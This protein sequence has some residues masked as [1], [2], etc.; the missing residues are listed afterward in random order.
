[1]KEQTKNNWRLGFAICL[2]I[3]T[4]GILLPLWIVGVDMWLEALDFAINTFGVDR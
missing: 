4:L 3:F 1:M 2:I